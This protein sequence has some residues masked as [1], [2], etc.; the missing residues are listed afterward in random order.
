[1]CRI[2]AQFGC[3]SKPIPTHSRPAPPRI[4]GPRASQAPINYHASE[5]AIWSPSRHDWYRVSHNIN[6]SHAAAPADA[7]AAPIACALASTLPYHTTLRPP[8]RARLIYRRPHLLRAAHWHPA[9]RTVSTSAL[10][11]RIDKRGEA[12]DSNSCTNHSGHWRATHT[13][14]LPPLAAS[15]T[16][17]TSVAPQSRAAARRCATA[18]VT[19]YRGQ[20]SGRLRS[21]RLLPL[22]GSLLLFQSSGSPISRHRLAGDCSLPA[23]APPST[24]SAVSHLILADRAAHSA[25]P[26]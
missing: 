12:L 1:V 20:G 7:P 18:R 3:Y 14:P 4:P 8:P 22:L 5:P 25:T 16:G 26:T 15:G 24:P 10:L 2:R 21:P 6:T 13:R 9:R 19:W 23:C 17:V 11:R